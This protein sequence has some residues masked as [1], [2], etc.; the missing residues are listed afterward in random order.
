MPTD[1][2]CYKSVG[3][4]DNANN[5]GALRSFMLTGMSREQSCARSG[6]LDNRDRINLTFFCKFIRSGSCRRANVRRID[7]FPREPAR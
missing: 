7:C 1:K 2:S 4:K 5:R 6:K 3:H